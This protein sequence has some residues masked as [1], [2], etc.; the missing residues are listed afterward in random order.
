MFVWILLR[1][2]INLQ[3]LLFYSVWLLQVIMQA[4]IL[5][6]QIKKFSFPMHKPQLF[7][8]FLFF[9]FFEGQGIVLLTVTN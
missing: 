8:G 6:A 7:V 9:F 3:F 1:K 2:K 5:T 4:G